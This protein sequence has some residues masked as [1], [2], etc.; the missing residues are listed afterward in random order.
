MEENMYRLV[1]RPGVIIHYLLIYLMLIANASAFYTMHRE[2][3]P[4]VM[5]SICVLIALLKQIRPDKNITI[6]GV[7]LLTVITVVRLMNNGGIGINI[8][9][10]F[11]S[12]C[13]IVYTAYSYDPEFF[14]K[15]Y[16]KLVLFL[17]G[18]SLVFYTLSHINTGLARSILGE[19]Y[20]YFGYTYYGR[21]LYVLVPDMRNTGIYSEPGLF[22]IVIIS[23][24]FFLMYLPGRLLISKRQNIISQI[25]LITALITTGSATGYICLGVLFIGI[26]FH[27][28]D[29]IKRFA[30]RMLIAA[31]ALLAV[32]YAVN[33]EDSILKPYLFD[34]LNELSTSSGDNLKTGDARIA[35]AQLSMKLTAR[36]PLGAGV[37]KFGLL[38]VEE[39]RT[40]AA[41]G[42][43]FYYLAVLGIIGWLSVMWYIFI[44]G[45]K[46]MPDKTSFLVF[47]AL[48][49]IY[50][51]SQPYILSPSVLV[52]IKACEY[53]ARDDKYAGAAV[54]LKA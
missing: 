26:L 54:L 47:I 7:V 9:L 21:F 10:D 23:C 17:S 41:G 15:R 4:A 43:L 20:N 38:K 28:K 30:F 5:I 53:T 35:V 13:L 32:D 34:K 2:I 25:I 45:Y 31:I 22:Q 19:G 1:I 48:Y 42:G 44:P 36:Y 49:I 39:L 50:S 3:L 29:S 51:I 40:T 16:S 6:F 37:E 14:L 33:R 46:Y 8:F 18:I 12:K 24:L 27:K 52:M 11:I